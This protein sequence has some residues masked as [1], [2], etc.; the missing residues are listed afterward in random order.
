MR[1]YGNTISELLDLN[2]QLKKQKGVNKK[3]LN[4]NVFTLYLLCSS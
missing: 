3:W 2:V 4:K 1:A